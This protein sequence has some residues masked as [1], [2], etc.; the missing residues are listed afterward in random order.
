MSTRDVL[1]WVQFIN[2]MYGSLPPHLLLQHGGH[3]VFLDALGCGGCTDDVYQ[4]CVDMLHSLCPAHD[5]GD[6]VMEVDRD[7]MYGIHPFYIKKG[8]LL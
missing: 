5:N 3:L 8:L 6:D 7:N 1:V 4:R 2:T